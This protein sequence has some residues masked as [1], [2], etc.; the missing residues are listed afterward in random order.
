MPMP[1][2]SERF[3]VA[4]ILIALCWAIPARAQ[5][6]LRNTPA[7]FCAISSLASATKIT[8]SNCVFGSFTG[9]ITGTTLAVTSVTGSLL[10]G[11]VVVGTGVTAGTYI[12]AQIPGGT[13]GGVGNYQLNNLQTVASESMTTSGVPQ[14]SDYAVLCAYV[15]GINYRDDPTPPTATLGTGGQAIVPSSSTIPTC[16]G[17][18]GTLTNLQFIQQ[19]SGAILGISFYQ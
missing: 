16:I 4:A 8:T 2:R 10:P 7:G 12:T 19:A 15:Q 17:Y 18:N 9:S 5:S 13:P 6:G 11:Q 14:T 3:L 1:R